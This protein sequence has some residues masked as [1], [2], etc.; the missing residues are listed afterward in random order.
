MAKD[1]KKPSALTEVVTREYTIHL[2]KYVFGK[3]FKKRAPTAIKAIR[4]FAEKA[5]GTTDVRLHPD[6]N[7]EV[8]KRGIKSVPTRLRIRLSRKRNDAED[9]KEKLYTYVSPVAVTSFKG[10]QTVTVDE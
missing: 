4:K 10:L 3:T 2:H 5:M 1:R 6:L 9:A 7:K 8:W